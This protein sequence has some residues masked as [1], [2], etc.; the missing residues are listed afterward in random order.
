MPAWLRADL[1]F[2][3]FF[4][5]RMPG[6]SPQFSLASPLPGPA[7]IKLAIIDSAIQYTGDPEYG[8]SIFEII[9]DSQVMAIPPEYVSIQ[10]F[11]IKRLKKPKETGSMVVESTA[12]REYCHLSGPLEIF[13][14]VYYP[15]EI[16]QLFLKIN[17]LGTT[18]SL[19][20]SSVYE[21]TKPPEELC[22]KKLDELTLPVKGINYDKRLVVSL[23]D[24]KKGIKFDEVNPFSD[25]K[26]PK[27]FEQSSFIL[28]LKLEKR[29][30]SWVIFKRVPFSLT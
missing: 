21:S 24:F 12:I 1:E 26:Q 29:G 15:E 10:K 11:F 13:L 20:M 9:K 22:W 19:L 28:P 18:D 23:T 7:A 8:R 6:L 25:V 14:E 30:K 16:K 5:Y 27:P 4:S 2:V 17:R 3:C